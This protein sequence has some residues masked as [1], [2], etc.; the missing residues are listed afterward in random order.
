[1]SQ[2]ASRWSLITFSAQRK[3]TPDFMLFPTPKAPFMLH[4]SF[5][6]LSNALMLPWKIEQVLKY[7]CNRI[8]MEN[9]TNLQAWFKILA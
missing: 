6:F 1:M 4:K 9:N 3:P 5:L 7:V 8:S 2:W